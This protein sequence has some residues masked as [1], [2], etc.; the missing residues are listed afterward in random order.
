MLA[1]IVSELGQ[2][3]SLVSDTLSATVALKGVYRQPAH[4][5]DR[6][7]AL[8]GTGENERLSPEEAAIAAVGLTKKVKFPTEIDL[9]TSFG[10][11]DKA[12]VTWIYELDLV[13]S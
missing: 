8:A 9:A 2:N 1:A 10:D 11:P 6:H 5:K 7:A 4:C 13:R 12:T 3:W